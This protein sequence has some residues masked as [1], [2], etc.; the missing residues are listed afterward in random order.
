MFE[1][2]KSTENDAYALHSQTPRALGKPR[3]KTVMIKEFS[4]ELEK[5]SARTKETNFSHDQL[6]QLYN[7]LFPAGSA[8]ISFPDLLESLNHH[9]QILKKPGNVYCYLAYARLMQ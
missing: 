4:V 2:F 1:C 7:S 8:S 6:K 5:I 3:S 9:G